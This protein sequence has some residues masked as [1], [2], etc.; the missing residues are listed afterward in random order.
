[1]SPRGLRDQAIYSSTPFA[2]GASS[3]IGRGKEYSSSRSPL[4]K[5]FKRI[6]HNRTSQD[7]GGIPEINIESPVRVSFDHEGYVLH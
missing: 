2:G 5:L 7:S 3:E 1:M 6:Y 4:G